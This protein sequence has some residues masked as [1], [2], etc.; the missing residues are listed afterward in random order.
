MLDFILELHSLQNKFAYFMMTEVD[1]QATEPRFRHSYKPTEWSVSSKNEQRL[2][3]M[4]NIQ[5]F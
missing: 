2:P 3:D 5:Y 4:L 1:I